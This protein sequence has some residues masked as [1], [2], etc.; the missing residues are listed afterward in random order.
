MVVTTNCT[1][2]VTRPENGAFVGVVDGIR[3]FIE[4]ASAEIVAMYDDGVP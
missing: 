2:S 3:G 1:I 4:P